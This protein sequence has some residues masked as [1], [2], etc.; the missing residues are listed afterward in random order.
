MNSRAGN[1]DAQRS[2]QVGDWTV[3]PGNGRLR[4]GDVEVKLEPRVMDLLVCLARRPGEVITR[5]ELEASVWS[6]SVVGYDAL[7]SAM[8]KLRRAF[9]DNSRHPRVIETVSKKGYRLIAAVSECRPAADDA[10]V[11]I[12]AAPLQSRT[13]PWSSATRAIAVFVGLVA[14]AY[15]LATASRVSTP[16]HF[17]SPRVDKP[18]LVVLPFVNMSND[19]GEEYFSDGITDDL[20]TDLSKF[21]GLFVVA[22]RT[23]FAYKQR[24]MDAKE[25]GKELSVSHVLEGSVRKADGQVRINAQLIDTDTGFHVWAERYDRRLEDIFAVQDDVRHRIVAALSVS[26]T[27]EEKRRIARRYTTSV[28]AYDHFLRGQAYFARHTQQDNRL[29]R[30]QFRAAIDLDPSFARAY[31]ALALANVDDFRY[32]WSQDSGRSAKLALDLATK[33]VALDKELPQAH[34]VLGYVHLFGNGNHEQALAMGQRTIALDPNHADGYALL[35]VT[36]VYAG[37]SERAK[38]LISEAMRLNPDSP[39]QYAA[40]LGYARFFGG[41]YTGARRALEQALEINVNRLMPNLYL[42]ATYVRL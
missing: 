18:S 1:G 29:A 3:E 31:S 12:P 32:Q 10:P 26:L 38:A 41:D 7:T 20:I 37:Q 21:S 33:A 27:E 15:F 11:Q 4:R 23:A 19:P 22:R 9:G 42:T 30:E 5:E 28:G 25:V 40:V 16:K 17:E 35:A 6:G 39:S 24:T 8:I 14:L 36:H 13:S 34:W 2:F